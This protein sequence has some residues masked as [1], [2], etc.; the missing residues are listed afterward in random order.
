MEIKLSGTEYELLLFFVNNRGKVLSHE[1]IYSAL[2]SVWCEKNL[3]ENAV[4]CLVKKLRKKLDKETSYRIQTV[5]KI[6]YRFSID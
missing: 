2:F 1:E 5:H 4:W 3:I 6:G